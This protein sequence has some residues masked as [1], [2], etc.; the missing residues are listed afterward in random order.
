MSTSFWHTAI[1]RSDTEPC[2]GRLLD[3]YFSRAFYKQI[4]GKPVDMRDFESI[5][6][7]Y[8]KSLQWMLDN[9]I[10]GVIEQEFVI[11]DDEFGEKK[12]VELKE[13]GTKIPVTDDN[14]QEYVQAVVSYRL[15][16][17]IKDQIKAFLNG[18]FDVIP[19]QLIQIFEPDQLEREP[20]LCP[21]TTVQ[22]D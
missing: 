18:F 19:R 14:K 16:N 3:A 10:D 5:D 21:Y 20:A 6:P 22:R 7:E 9:P 1:P 15:D 11:E 2:S 17:S 13:G 8:H 4:L 12:I